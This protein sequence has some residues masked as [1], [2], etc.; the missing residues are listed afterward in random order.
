[1]D[2]E[3]HAAAVLYKGNFRRDRAIPVGSGC[4]YGILALFIVG[5]AVV[6]LVLGPHGVDGLVA[7]AH[8]DSG[9][10]RGLRLGRI[11][12]AVRLILAPAHEHYMVVLRAK[13]GIVTFVQCH[14]GVRLIL[15][16]VCGNAVR[17]AAVGVVGQGVSVGFG[18]VG[19][20]VQIDFGN[21]L[22]FQLHHFFKVRAGDINFSPRIVVLIINGDAGYRIVSDYRG[23]IQNFPG[24]EIV[25][26][27]IDSSAP[28]HVVTLV[29]LCKAF[30]CPA[31]GLVR[32][33]AGDLPFLH[34][35]S[36]TNQINLDLINILDLHPIRNRL[37]DVV[38]V[39]DVEFG[40]VCQ[41]FPIITGHRIDHG[42]LGGNSPL[43]ILR[44]GQ[45]DLITLR[46]SGVQLVLC[47]VH[48]GAV[49]RHIGIGRHRNGVDPGI[50]VCA[51]A[52]DGVGRTVAA[53][54]QAIGL[55]HMVDAGLR[56]GAVDG[57]RTGS[58]IAE[59]VLQLLL[60]GGQGRAFLGGGLLGVILIIVDLV[61]HGRIVVARRNRRGVGQR[62]VRR[63]NLGDIKG[64]G[65]INDS[66]AS[67]TIAVNG[68]GPVVT[69]YK[70][71]AV[72][73]NRIVRA[74]IAGDGQLVQQGHFGVHRDGDD[75]AHGEVIIRRSQARGDIVRTRH[76][77]LFELGD[78]GLVVGVGRS[79]SAIFPLG[80]EG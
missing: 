75:A 56:G 76:Q 10:R 6:V 24:G 49:L 1:M 77:F 69:I 71:R 78:S 38:Q 8:G 43:R 30:N 51:G 47:V 70:L 46:L 55:F 45:S 32:S 2:G 60:G 59:Q 72:V 17:V 40:A 16:K 74:H 63:I 23:R 19:G 79:R 21:Q 14:F 26:V 20:G 54:Q 31:N 67:V 33:A 62:A 13:G 58:P 12:R 44:P 7:G 39:H 11:G 61:V 48:V 25:Q 64:L 4:G 35:P 15:V 5:L 34:G 80:V 57:H 66:G 50:A 28:H 37:L 3:L 22:P 65:D 68:P 36:D 27:S 18:L 9:L 73:R 53:I 29:W 52:G 41:H 42:H